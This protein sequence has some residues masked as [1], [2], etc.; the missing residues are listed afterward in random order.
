M[1]LL[2][3]GDS[4]IGAA[5]F[6]AL[7]ARGIASAATTRRKERV[8]ADRPFLDLLSP[9]DDWEPPTGTSAVCICAAVARMTAC[10]ADPRGS[11]HVNVTQTIAIADRLLS[12]GIPVLFL[13]TNQV[14]D[15]TVPNV[16]SDARPSPISE[17]GRQKALAEAEFLLRIEK[18]APAAILRLAKVTSPD[19]QLLR[20]W[21]VTLATGR[22]IRAFSDM[23]MAPIETAMVCDAIALLMR[24][25]P[26]GI[27]QLSLI[28][29]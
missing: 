24:A 15:G 3:G 6:Q 9:L 17:Y 4:E 18:D 5:A 29:I 16:A 2:I 7:K 12:R 11:A 8:A 21:I 20:D 26:R 10:E 25:A 19:M 27:F 23:T 14:F 28:H 22:P 13:S 1:W